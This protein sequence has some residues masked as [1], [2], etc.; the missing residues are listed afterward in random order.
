MIIKTCDKCGGKININP[1]SNVVFPSFVIRKLDN[2]ITGWQS[3]D[4]CPKCEEK[5]N[6]KLNQKEGT[7]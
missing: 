7:E 2:F 5:L 4:L 3:V 1:A 6:R